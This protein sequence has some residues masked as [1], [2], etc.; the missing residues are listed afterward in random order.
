MTTPDDPHPPLHL[1]ARD[2]PVPTSVSPQAQAMLAQGIVGPVANWPAQGDMQGWRTMV[3]AM[4]A[5]L[6]AMI[7]AGAAGAI[8][9]GT[10]VQDLKVGD[11]AVYAVT[12]EGVGPDDRRVCLDIHGGSWI[13]AGGAICRASAIATA[14]RIG[15][16]LWSVDYRMPPDHP[17]P[18]PLDDCVAVY[19][20]LLNDH[21]P[22]DIIVNGVS[23][24]GNLAAALVLRVRDE[25]LPW[26]AAVVLSTPATDLTEAGDTWQTNMGID[27]L[28]TESLRPAAL[29]Y[30]G[31]HDLRDPYLS[32]LFGDFTKGFPPT[33]LLSGTRDCLLSDTVRMHRALRNAGV[34]ADLHVFEAAGHGGFLGSAPE[35]HDRA[36]EIRRFVDAH[37]GRRSR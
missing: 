15:A 23:A 37:W 1:P 26:P 33:A 32:P 12:P 4:E 2:I 25:G 22:E 16:P 9:A 36:Q 30:S 35:D 34:P 17:Y 29:L 19:R 13:L 28:L 18:T 3:A 31:G 8:P 20:A 14:A 5:D 24:G 10:D 11:V 27:A 6:V 7:T 21:R